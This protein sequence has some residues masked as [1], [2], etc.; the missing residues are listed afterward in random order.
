M[1]GHEQ[2]W[3]E[4]LP[5]RSTTSCRICSIAVH[6]V[7]AAFTVGKLNDVIVEGTEDVIEAEVPRKPFATAA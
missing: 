1:A 7:L 6:T 5:R 2:V 4:S 3:R